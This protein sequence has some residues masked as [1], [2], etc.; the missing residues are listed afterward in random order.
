MFQAAR[1]DAGRGLELLSVT[2]AVLGGVNIFG[3]EGRVPDVLAALLLVTTVQAAM[4][5]ANIP[6]AW[7]LGAVG[8]PDLRASCSA[9]ARGRCGR[10]FSAARRTTRTEPRLRTL[11]ARPGDVEVEGLRDGERR[12]CAHRAA[13]K[14]RR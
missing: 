5:L 7:Q 3:G 8:R 13:S 10:P 2:V 4:Q 1:P 14:R 12:D 9:R 6:Q 11:A